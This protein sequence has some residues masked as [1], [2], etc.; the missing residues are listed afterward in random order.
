MS[1]SPSRI[2]A[3]I[4]R[5]DSFDFLWNLTQMALLIE[6][7]DGDFVPIIQLQHSNTITGWTCEALSDN[8]KVRCKMPITVRYV[9]P[10][11]AMPETRSTSGKMWLA[12][13][14]DVRIT[15]L[16]YNLW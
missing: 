7:S 12:S 11:L 16:T 3:P 13:L 6:P 1:R 5:L 14:A 8:H 4:L 10:R 15:I 9:M 2:S